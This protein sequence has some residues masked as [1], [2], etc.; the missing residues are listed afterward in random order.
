M[1]KEL[2]DIIQ[3]C[4][5]NDKK[6]QL[7]LYQLFSPVMY[8][9]CLKYMKNKSDADD[10]FQEAFII[11][12][13]KIHQYKFKGSFEGWLKRIFINKA[14]ETL[15]KQNQ[16]LHITT[17]EFPEESS[18]DIELYDDNKTLS[19]EDLL[20]CL[21]QLPDKYRT[22]FSLY[23]IEKYNH[24]GISNLLQIAVGTS[25]SL[26]SRAKAMLRTKITLELKRKVS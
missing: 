25:K 2:H 26:L 4:I 20:H 3:L 10:V 19:Q 11:V 16:Y 18:N 17:D 1:K 22:V 5:K 9:I 6:G 21:Q 12:F 7:A 15:R 23:V 8:G 14:L 13:Q 24:K